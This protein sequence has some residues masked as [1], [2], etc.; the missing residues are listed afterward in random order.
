MTKYT[1]CNLIVGGIIQPQGK[2]ITD[3]QLDKLHELGIYPLIY[4]V[5]K[6]GIR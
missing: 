5:E 2:V 6:G 3:K 1:K 4:H